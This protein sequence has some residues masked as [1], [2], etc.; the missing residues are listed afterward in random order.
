MSVIEIKEAVGKLSPAELA[1]VSAFIESR[2]LDWLE[3]S[4]RT[5]DERLESFDQGKMKAVNGAD[6]V[7]KL[8]QKLS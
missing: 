6:A 1:E 7:Y 5:A 2:E 3:R 4:G 8:R